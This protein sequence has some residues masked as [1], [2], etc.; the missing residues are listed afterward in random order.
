[1]VGYFV[2]ITGG[3][4][5]LACAHGLRR[6]NEDKRRAVM[7]L[8][9]D[10]EWVTWSDNAIAKACNVSPHTVADAKKS[11]YAFAEIPTDAK[12]SIFGNSDD[13]HI[14]TV[15]RNGVTYEQNTASIGKTKPAEPA[16]RQR[17]SPA[18]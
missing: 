16:L 5:A 18:G 8:L 3:G 14:R 7:T 11:I 10:A 1:M 17:I 4:Q 13:S 6:S 15:E 9:N 12:K 2:A